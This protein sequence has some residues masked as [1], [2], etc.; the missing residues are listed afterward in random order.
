M[1]Y[2]RALFAVG[3][4]GRLGGRRGYQLVLIPQGGRARHQVAIAAR[5]EVTEVGRPSLEVRRLSIQLTALDAIHNSHMTIR[6]ALLRPLTTAALALTALL[7]LRERIP[8]HE[9]AAAGPQGRLVC[10]V[11]RITTTR[12]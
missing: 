2:G 9:R 12:L 5:G 3:R 4:G 6:L 1:E 10:F 8:E 11:I 7:V